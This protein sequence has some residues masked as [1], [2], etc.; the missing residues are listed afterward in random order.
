MAEKKNEQEIQQELQ[1]LIAEIN[2]LQGQMEAI[3]AQIDL[4]ESSISE[5]NRVEETLKGVKELEG[6]EEVLVPVGAQSFVRACVTDTERVIV[7]IGAGVAVE[8]TID[9]ALESIDDQRQELEK[10]RAE[11]QQKLQELAQ[12]LQE[13]QRKAQ[14]LAQQLEGAQRI[15]QQSGGG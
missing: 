15:A 14:E 11:A 4:I 6:D 13:K 12:E 5:L 1:R 9:E 7:G 10:A 8:R 2:R 3:N